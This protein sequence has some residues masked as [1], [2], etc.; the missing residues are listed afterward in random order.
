M[1][2]SLAVASALT[3]LALSSARATEVQIGDTDFAASG[4]P[5]VPFS[6]TSASASASFTPKAGRVFHLTIPAG[7]MAAVCYV[8]RKPDGT[9]WTPLTVFGSNI[10]VLTL[11]GLAVSEDLYEAQT[12]VPYRLDC[13]ASL[14][15][16]ASGPVAGSFTQ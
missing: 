5:P 8:E 9:N 4:R 16:Y 10:E 14:G 15:S 2:K 13:G 12:N 3:L 1:R 11:A 6:L 7:A